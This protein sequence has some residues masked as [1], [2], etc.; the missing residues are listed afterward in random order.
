MRFIKTETNATQRQILRTNTDRQTWK[1]WY[2]RLWWSIPGR[3]DFHLTVNGDGCFVA[4]AFNLGGI[5]A[6]YLDNTKLFQYYH[7][8]S[9]QQLQKLSM[10]VGF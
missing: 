1:F 6:L 2:F 9:P 7:S 4:D 10:C 8:T 5:D 3:P